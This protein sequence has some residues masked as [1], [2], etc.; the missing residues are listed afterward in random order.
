[1]SRQAAE[2]VEA[3]LPHGD[4]VDRDR[5]RAYDPAW[6]RVG[7]R[8]AFGV[9]FSDRMTMTQF[10][11][12]PP[13]PP[14]TA[15]GPAPWSATAI[16]GFV[17]ALLGCTGVLA[18]LG[19]ILGIVGI[20][21]TGDGLRRGRGLAIAAIPVSLATGLLGLAF[22]AFFII[23]AAGASFI[24]SIPA[25]IK[26]DATE[27]EQAIA[28]VREAAT[29]DFNQAVS[30]GQ[31][32]AWITQLQEKHGKFITMEPPV[33][34]TPAS[35]SRG[36]VVSIPIKFVNGKGIVQ[37]TFDWEGWRPALQDIQIDGVSP[38]DMPE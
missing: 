15:A 14:Y 12:P 9:P 7:V 29:E 37:I 27:M 34:G 33:P 16:A 24:Q 10:S 4:T 18:P 30:D 2:A 17:C 22:W 11:P 26:A 32:T 3:R 31:V 25:V 38:R 13:Q 35:G 19:L 28:I 5:R 36:G 6:I 1:M 20:Y 23:A 8:A 21:K